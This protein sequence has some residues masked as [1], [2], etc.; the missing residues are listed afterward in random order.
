MT[1]LWLGACLAMLPLL[2]ACANDPG[3][4]PRS[5]SGDESACADATVT[6]LGVPFGT[7][8]AYFRTSGGQLRIGVSELGEDLFGVVTQ[9]GVDLGS[10]PRPRVD[11]ASNR[12]LNATTSVTVHVDRTTE[13][14]LP[15]GEYWLTSSNGGRIELRT[16]PG[17]TISEVSPAD[18]DPG[19]AF[20]SGDSSDSP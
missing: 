14:S 6:E 8:V 19:A 9:T 18:G 11:P 7:R 15:A 5:H 3:A 12:V 16:C 10:S 4:S 13:V 17:V 20:R 1:R 2:A